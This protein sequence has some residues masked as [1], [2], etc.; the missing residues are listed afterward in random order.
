M[1]TALAA[2]RNSFSPAELVSRQKSGWSLERPFYLDSAIFELDVER[3]W[4]RQWLFAGHANSLAKSGDYF[5]VE[6]GGESLILIRDQ[7][8]LI[9]AL[10]NSC[11]HRG[12]RVCIEPAGNKRSLVCPYHQ[13]VYGHDGTLLS[14]R[15][16]GEDFDKSRFGLRRI[17]AREVE[18]LI[19]ICFAA[20]RLHSSNQ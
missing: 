5:L 20:E 15:L 18:G 19:F 14:A 4:H 3:V 17:H 7:C 6:V 9:H 13:W 10:I 1:S 12:S 8:D 2:N 16:M 11:R